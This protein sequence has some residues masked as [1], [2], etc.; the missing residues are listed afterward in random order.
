MAG[1]AA[2]RSLRRLLAARSTLPRKSHAGWAA[3]WAQHAAASN[4]AF[5]CTA[6][7][8]MH[9]CARC[10]GAALPRQAVSNICEQGR[11]PAGACEQAKSELG[12]VLLLLLRLPA[13]VDAASVSTSTGI[14]SFHF[15]TPHLRPSRQQVSS[16][17]PV[18]ALC[19]S[20]SPWPQPVPLPCLSTAPAAGRQARRA[21]A[22][23]P[24]RCNMSAPLAFTARSGALSRV[25]RA[26]PV[27]Q[28]CRLSRAP[29]PLTPSW[30]QLLAG[31]GPRSQRHAY[32]AA[33]AGGAAHRASLR[34]AQAHRVCA[35]P[36]S[37]AGEQPGFCC[38]CRM[39][40]SRPAAI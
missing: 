28:G 14:T 4:P 17:Q 27:V 19:W 11:V 22:N 38:C 26:T 39:A 5:A 37:A 12:K 16:L 7:A 10:R 25:R 35:G 32:A 20:R 1:D 24:C 40:L 23:A 33:R 13:A 18:F 6:C 29:G 2:R 31:V 30:P 8:R 3:G 34:A 9:A 21:V 36:G 15:T